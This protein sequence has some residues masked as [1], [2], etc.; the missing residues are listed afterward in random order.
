MNSLCYFNNAATSFPKPEC[1]KKSVM[2]FFTKPPINSS[3]HCNCIKKSTDVDILCKSK[4]NQFLNV[5]ESK[6]DIILTP[7]A[8]YS[9]NI[10]INNFKLQEYTSIYVHLITNNSVHN[11]I[12]RT[13]YEKIHSQ[14]III[15]DI[16]DIY[17]IKESE[18]GYG[19]H[20]YYVALSHC[21][22]VDGSVLSDE[23]IEIV[24]NYCKKHNN[25]P[26]ILDITQ[27]IGTF[28]ID[29]NKW[30]YDNLYI[31]C[32]CHK[33]LYATQGI[34]F[35]IY[36]KGS[37]K[38]N[39]ISGGSGGVNSIDY[40]KTDTLEPG[41]QNELAMCSLIAGIDYVKKSTLKN[42][43]IYKNIIY[44][45]FINLYKEFIKNNNKFTKIFELITPSDSD[46]KYSGIVC[47]K[48]LDKQ[49][50]EVLIENLTEKYGIITRSGVHCTPLYHIN[51]LHCNSTWRLSFSIHNTKAELQYLFDSIQKELM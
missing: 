34:G 17:N 15:N 37:I 19:D 7:G 11:S 3:R 24:I 33:G 36:P 6:Y 48:I 14:P 32:S 26:F 2:D 35:L 20:N 1:V 28:D 42:I 31:I 22:N 18:F 30:N 43:R 51:K 38:T 8:T 41:T 5:D 12:I 44:T 29:I 21:N 45:H 23:E 49:K 13:H 10:V 16:K 40:K 27:S 39:L 47:F 9:A 50:A 46:H 25:I 4:I